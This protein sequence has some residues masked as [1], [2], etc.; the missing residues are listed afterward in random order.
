MKS[1]L[2]I[3]VFLLNCFLLV[4][5]QALKIASASSQGFSEQRLQKIDSLISS[6]IN[7]HK[8]AGVDALIARHGNIVYHK[9]FGYRNAENKIPLQTTDL[10]RIASQTKAI[11]SVALMILYEE[12]KFSLDDP[13]SKYIPEFK[14]PTVLKSFNDKD[15]SYTTEPAKREI[16]I[17]D[18]FT[19][20]SGIGYAIIG[21]K[22]ANAI[23]SK[24]K[25]SMGFEPRKRLLADQIKL[26]AQQPLMH[27]PGEKWT[28]GLNIDV[29]GYLIEVLSG[30]SFKDFLEERLFNPL[31]MEDTYFYVPASKHSR[32]AEVYKMTDG[33]FLAGDKDSAKVN[34]FYPLSPYAS[35]YSGGAGLVSTSYD[36]ALFM[37]MILNK[38]TLNGKVILSPNTIRLIASNQIGDLTLGGE[39][40]MGL[41]FSIA[42][43]NANPS[44][45]FNAGTLAWGGF[46]G[47]EYWIDPVADIVVQIWSQS[48]LSDL[49]EKFKVM[50]YAAMIQ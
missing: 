41:G 22:E 12:G 37:Q 16:T 47:S 34:D 20:T 9:A 24:A 4:H 42:R 28:Y 17:R 5:G 49:N 13:V 44:I 27:Q 50:V 25:I 21:S 18:L 23:Y 10:F 1:F 46:W 6:Y 31:G 43:P 45:P 30:K 40:K 32:L 48:G 11:T 19:H 36:Y 26:L 35:Y 15:S 8:I 14:N 2:G 7:E 29:L 38:G 33:K 39:D 3:T